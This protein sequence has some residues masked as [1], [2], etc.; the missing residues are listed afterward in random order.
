MSGGTTATPSYGFGEKP[1]SISGLG[2]VAAGMSGKCL[3]ATC[4][5]GGFAAVRFLCGLFIRGGSKVSEYAHNVFTTETP[6]APGSD[7]ARPQDTA[8]TP[9]SGRVDVYVEHMGYLAGCQ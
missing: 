1:A 2:N 7:A 8:I 9:S 4:P 6:V 3:P 5:D